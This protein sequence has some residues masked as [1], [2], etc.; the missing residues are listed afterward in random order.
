MP[1]DT[2]FI[3]LASAQRPL[4]L[5]FDVGGTN[6]KLGVVD[7]LG[8][9]VAH[10]KIVTEEDRG[11]RDAV[12][13][14]RG[15][16][17]EV[18]KSLGLAIGDLAAIGLCVPGTMDIPRG[19]FLEPHNLPHW[20]YFPIRDCVADAF[21]LPVSFANDANAASYGELWVGSGK[22][23]R[24]IVLLTLGTGVGGGIIVDDLSI[25][26][27]HSHGSECGHIIVD[28]TP[29]ARMCGCGQVGHLEAYCSAT[30]LVAR[31]HEL[32]AQGRT[33]SLTNRIG[34][35]SPL[36]ALM[37]AEEADG[38]DSLS[39]E[40]IMELATWLGLGIVSLMHTIDPGA[41]ILGGAMNFGGHD[42]SV[43]RRF[44][45]QVR[46]IV[47]KRAFPIPA[48]RT[49]IDFAE[50]GSDAGFIGAAGIARLEYHRK[51]KAT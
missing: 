18:L 13:R 24:S 29:A 10:T 14:A 42:D 3:D 28:N 9:P 26:G 17:D 38:G 19:M 7:D 31:T 32:I 36:T 6:I 33:T 41:V 35:T 30:A 12:K 34:E 27:E 44:I 48:Q 25:D 16:V 49:V 47:R 20:H 37:I 50:L 43:G 11:P 23:Y 15:A 40:V 51:R 22:Q 5:G 1:H 2:T 21:G 4:F 39:F 8:R 45:E 46:T